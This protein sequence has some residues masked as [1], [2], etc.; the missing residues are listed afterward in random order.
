MRSLIQILVACLLLPAAQPSLRA[1]HEHHQQQTQE[2]PVSLLNGMGNHTHTIK[3]SN[4]EAQK[5]FNQG[6]NMLF[7][8]NRYEALRSFRKAAEL[9]PQAPMP[10]WGI[11]MATGPGINMDMD[12]EVDLKGSCAAI[13]KASSLAKNGTQ[14]ERDY[15][16]AARVRC[17]EY[18]GDKYIAAMRSLSE[19]YPDDLDAATLFAESIMIPVRWRWFTLDGKPAGQ[20]ETAIA[21][22]E[23]VMRRNAQHPGA[24][25]FYI[26]AVEMS[27]SPE[28]AVPSAQR[29][30]GV[31]PEAGHL[32]HMPGHIWMILGR[33]DL[34]VDTNERAVEVDEDYFAK[35]KVNSGYAGYYLHNIHFV[36][37]GNEMRGNKAGSYA[38]AEKLK[39]AASVHIDAMPSMA[40]AFIAHY[41]FARLRFNDWT[42]ILALPEPDAR[43]KANVALHHFARALALQNAG[44]LELAKQECS[45]FDAAQK[46]IPADWMWLNNKTTDIVAVASELL[47][48]RLAP[49]LDKK[50]EHLQKA[51][52]LEDQLTYDE[53]PAFYY[54]IR[55]TLGGELFRAGKF[56]EAEAVFRDGILRKP[57]NGRMLFGLWKTLEAQ[58]KAESAESVKREFEAAW[59]QADVRLSMNDL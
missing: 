6:L 19:R 33:Y 5:F 8:F 32:V 22:L 18:D 31:M 39:K 30:M 46:A 23:G 41:L 2:Q 55:E 1:Q 36:T 14:R 52:A 24:N 57:G 3:T 9:D 21:V 49:S 16:E 58:G 37:V 43:L 12:A 59:K 51:I 27:P 10:L 7:G 13:E 50:V 26:H 4:P 34:V 20:M 44:K 29:L 35:T 53:P 11:A 48:A 15:I 17:P 54:P 25:H 56:A 28:R 40:D 47:K 45:Q 38:A 42:G